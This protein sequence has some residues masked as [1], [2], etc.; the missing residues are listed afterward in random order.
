MVTAA[1]AA[2]RKH[3]LSVTDYYRLAEAGSLSEDDRVELIEGEIIDMAPIGSEHGG[4]TKW[5]A[6]MFQRAVGDRAVVSIQDPVRLDAFSEPEPDIALLLPRADYYRGGHPCP[7]DVY[8]LVEV[9][10]TSL[11]YDRDVKIPLYA[12]H[13]VPAVWLIDLNA[14]HRAIYRAPGAGAYREVVDPAPLTITPLPGVEG[15]EIDLAGLF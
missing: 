10:G 3:R 12:R 6:R 7:Q 1:A 2:P 9:A 8:L 14:R 11:A 13:G 5:L 4:T 15:A